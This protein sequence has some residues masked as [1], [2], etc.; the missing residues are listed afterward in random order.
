MENCDKWG[1]GFWETFQ[2]GHVRQLKRKSNDDEGGRKEEC[3]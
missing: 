1:E 2:D 3:N